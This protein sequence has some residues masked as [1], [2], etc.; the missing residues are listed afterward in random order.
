MGIELSY[1]KRRGEETK[2]EIGDWIIIVLVILGLLIVSGYL[3][4]KQPNVYSALQTGVES[5]SEKT[6]KGMTNLINEAVNKQEVSQEVVANGT[7]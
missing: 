3:H 6:Y 4:D 1:P 2:M 7:G 5:V